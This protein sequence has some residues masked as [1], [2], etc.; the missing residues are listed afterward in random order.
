MAKDNGNGSVTIVSGDS[1]S[2]IAMKYYK[3]Y[4]YST[5]WSYMDLLV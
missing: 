4:G 5:W 2:A 3:T 1:L